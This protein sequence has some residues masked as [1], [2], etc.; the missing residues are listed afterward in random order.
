M[1]NIN[2]VGPNE[3]LIVS[4]GC[5]RP[6]KKPTLL[7]AGHGP[8]GYCPMFKRILQQ[9]LE[10]N[11]RSILGTMT[12]EEIYRERDQ[13]ASLVREVAS[14]ELE[15]MGIEILSF[16]IKDVYDNVNYLESL[17]KAKIAEIKRNAAIGVANAER[18]AGI[19][20]AECQKAAMDVKYSADAKIEDATRDY[21]TQKAMFE[22][23]VNAKKAEA[24]LAF[25]LRSTHLQQEIS[26]QQK[27]I[28]LIERKKL[29]EL[30]DQEIVLAEN[31][32]KAKVNLLADAQLYEI[33]QLTEG[34]KRQILAAAEADAER[35]K[36]IGQ[37]ESD[38]AEIRG[39]AEAHGMLTKASALKQ[40]GEAAILSLTLENLPKIA[41]EISAPLS[42]TDEIVL[43]SGDTGNLTKVVSQIPPTLQ[44][45]TGIDVK[46]T[47][48]KITG[49]H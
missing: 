17:G 1:G 48:S 31:D 22:A 42:K 10:G 28:E 2:T 27:F 46:K 25:D 3:A 24:N 34:K 45:M 38:A 47:L 37:A 41:A 35:I 21:L 49:A 8:G 30:Q 16:T 26:K 29:T 40:F 13:F 33:C 23:E 15:R 19:K 5:C 6:T 20:E 11:L 18:D 14:S 39:R 9:T 43:L 12:V 36:L 7:V 32:L 4:G 44:A